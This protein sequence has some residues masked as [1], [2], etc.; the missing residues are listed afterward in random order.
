MSRLLKRRSGNDRVFAN[1]PGL[2]ALTRCDTLCLMKSISIRELHER[3]GHWV[4]KAY[5]E[6]AIA[7]TDRGR[8][9]AVLGDIALLTGGDK[10]F[11]KRDRN[12]MPAVGVDSAD[13]ISSDRDR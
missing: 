8:R 3:T 11:P 1:I 12:A 2:T 5:R 13:L 4:R 7:V 9:I 6:G 10:P